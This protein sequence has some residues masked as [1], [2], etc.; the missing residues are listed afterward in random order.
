MLTG[1]LEPYFF[2]I[3]VVDKIHVVA[4]S[5]VRTYVCT[6]ETE[7]HVAVSSLNRVTHENF[8]N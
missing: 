8:S 7:T 6:P 4:R 2:T 3:R 1:S 5:V